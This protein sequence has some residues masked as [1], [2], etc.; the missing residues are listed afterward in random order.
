MRYTLKVH[1]KPSAKIDTTV[2]D[3]ARCE[4]AWNVHNEESRNAMIPWITWIVDAIDEGSLA[5]QFVCKSVFRPCSDQIKA[6]WPL[7]QPS[8]WESPEILSIYVR[9]ARHFCAGAWKLE[10]DFSPPAQPNGFGMN[11]FKFCV[12]SSFLFDFDWEISHSYENLDNNMRKDISILMNNGCRSHIIGLPNTLFPSS[13]DLT[14]SSYHHHYNS[15][16]CRAKLCCAIN[17]HQSANKMGE[18]VPFILHSLVC[19]TFPAL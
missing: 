7:S 15:L 14:F 9:R 10:I 17:F 18:A 6:F 2:R 4:S 11:E 3:A 5:R 19:R 8:T 16:L 12:S 13:F 1:W